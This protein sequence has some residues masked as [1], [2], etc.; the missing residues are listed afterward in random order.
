MQD[1]D[2]AGD[3]YDADETVLS[4]VLSGFSGVLTYTDSS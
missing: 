3:C 4:N 1:M 2:W